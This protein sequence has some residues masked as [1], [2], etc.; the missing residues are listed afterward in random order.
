MRKALINYAA[1]QLGWFSCV[2]GAAGGRPWL[3]PV[4][5]S[6]AVLVHL[7]MAARPSREFAL[8]VMCALL[9]LVF[10]SVLLWTGWV[11]YPDGGWIP[12]M[13]P[14]WMISLWIVFGSTLNLSMVWLRGRTWLGF[15]VGSI[16][17]PASYLAGESLNAMSLVQPIPALIALSL[18]WGL[19]LPAL[20]QLA[21]VFDGFTEVPRVS[22]LQTHW[23]DSKVADHG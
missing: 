12:G 4:V 6:F 18:G 7:L 2:L 1:F 9:G 14:Y 23:R 10:D 20:S 5:V 21:T 8:L 11:A 13:A 17:G 16:A 22:Y 19:I 3:G 15:L